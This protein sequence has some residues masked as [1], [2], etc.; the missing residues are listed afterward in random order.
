MSFGQDFLRGF[1]GASS[2]LKDYEHASKTFRT[3]GY[4]LSPR[5]KFLFHVFF[6]I[7]TGQI[8]A[9]QGIFGNG[10]VVS[11]GLSVKS[12]DLPSRSEEHTSEL[13]SH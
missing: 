12:T 13:Q 3:N 4:E 2:G 10:D 9:L 1:T 6:N 11:V 5:L 7:N 8:P